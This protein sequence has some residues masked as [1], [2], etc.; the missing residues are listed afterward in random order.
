MRLNCPYCGHPTKFI[1]S[2]TRMLVKERLLTE[3]R[4]CRN[5]SKHWAVEGGQITEVRYIKVRPQDTGDPL[6]N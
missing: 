5:C 6:R 4:F 2:E 3:Y 1:D